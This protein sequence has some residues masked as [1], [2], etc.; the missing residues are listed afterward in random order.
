MQIKTIVT[1]VLIMAIL[2]SM[3]SLLYL[4]SH[5]AYL[6]LSRGLLSVRLLDYYSAIMPPINPISAF[7]LGSI[8]NASSIICTNACLHGT[9]MQSIQISTFLC[10]YE[11]S[12]LD[13]A[14]WDQSTIPMHT[15]RQRLQTKPL[16]LMQR[17]RPESHALERA[18]ASGRC[19]EANLLRS[20]KI[21]RKRLSK[22]EKII[23]PP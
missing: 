14:M 5:S 9:K 23:Y 17:P 1:P 16:S 21:S 12:A 11:L 4:S 2:A 7:I 20:F 8:C 22:F 6:T 3:V 13:H 18:P 15:P 10:I 19:G